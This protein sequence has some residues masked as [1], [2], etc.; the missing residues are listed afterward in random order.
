M[1]TNL[2]VLLTNWAIFLLKKGS[3][4][5]E[6]IVR[7]TSGHPRIWITFLV[8]IVALLG[9]TSF[10]QYHQI[11]NFQFPEDAK[12]ELSWFRRYHADRGGLG[13]PAKG[14]PVCK[15]PFIPCWAHSCRSKSIA[16]HK[17]IL[18][19]LSACC[20][21]LNRVLLLR[22]GTGSCTSSLG[23]KL[24][25]MTFTM[26]HCCSALC[27]DLCRMYKYSCE[28]LTFFIICLCPLFPDFQ[29]LFFLC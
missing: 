6:Q 10:L 8:L 25:V 7:S 11:Q 20:K 23:W 12:V 29:K 14:F 13:I 15:L 3:W 21:N 18:G 5:P 26:R 16:V 24:P 2:D 9:K 22:V 19:V 27:R 17:L 28:N 1:E 4:S